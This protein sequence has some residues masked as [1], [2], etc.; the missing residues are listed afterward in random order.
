MTADRFSLLYAFEAVYQDTRS[1]DE[2]DTYVG[3]F[4][5]FRVKGEED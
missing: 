3:Q 2:S 5:G 1:I 4:D